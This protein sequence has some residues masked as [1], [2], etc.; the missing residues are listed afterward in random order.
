MSVSSRPPLP[1]LGSLRIDEGSRNTGKRGKR[2]GVF[3]AVLGLLVLLGGAFFALRGQKAVVDVATARPAGDPRTQAL[4]NASGYVTPRRRATVAAKITGRVTGVYTDEGMR[5]KSGQV[6][7]KLDDSDSRVRLTSA[8]ADK[9]AAAAAIEDLQVNLANAE[10]E[11]KRTQALQASGVQTIQALDQARTTVDSLKAR[12][13]LTQ[14][15]IRAADARILVAQQDVDNAT[16]RAPFEGLVVSK[17]AQVGEM[18]SPISAGG[19]FTRTGI[20]TLVD[21]NPILRASKPARRSWQPLTPIP[22][23]RFQRLCE[24]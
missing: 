21:M 4:L 14:Q 10:R 6:L 17:D 5:V 9:D 12:I 20:A 3:A 18:V 1:D 13:S 11:L 22:I 7:A 24:P 23:G 8:R 15:Q 19:G 2:L 16:I